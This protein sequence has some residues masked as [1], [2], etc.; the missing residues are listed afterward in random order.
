MSRKGHRAIL[1]TH[2]HTH[3]FTHGISELSNKAT[4]TK[5]AFLNAGLNKFKIKMT[6]KRKCNFQ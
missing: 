3:T 4:I 5:I 6:I 1:E 2:T